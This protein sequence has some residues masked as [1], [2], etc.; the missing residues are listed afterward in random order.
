MI[1]ALCDCNNFFVSCERR[2]DPSLEGLPVIVLSHNDGCVI[3]RSNEAK[4]LNIGMAVPFFTVRGICKAHG[5]VALKGDHTLY[6]QTSRDVM[7]C[8]G[9]LFPEVEVS[10]IDEAYLLL[11]GIQTLDP[12]R[13]CL[14]AR[15]KL[16][17]STGIPASFGIAPTKTL[18]KIASRF[19]KK[20]PS[21]NGVFN[22]LDH[23][24]AD[25]LLASLSV[26]DVWGIGSRSLERLRQMG[27]RTAL[28]L[29]NA[30]DEKLLKRF[31]I[32]M[33]RTSHEL[34]GVCC[35]SF[36]P[37]PESH[38]SI[39]IAPSFR[40][41]VTD[42]ET[43]QSTAAEHAVEAAKTLR[44]EG[45]VCGVVQVSIQTNPFR[46]DLPQYEATA[47]QRIE[48]PTDYS[49]LLADAA[50]QATEK[51]Y[52]PGYAYRRVGVVLGDL[53]DSSSRQSLLF[54]TRDRSREKKLMEAMDSINR[55]LG[56]DTI[57]PWFTKE[58]PAE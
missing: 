7:E 47:D 24:A 31:P 36:E 43:L 26:G 28:D 35:H 8:L 5:V 25:D 50:R 55:A 34:R 42:L 58:T 2:R 15:G 46:K 33:L 4:A 53:S 51:I 38:K 18:A 20:D 29:K 12:A 40:K 22:F 9:G 37:D 32:G 44:A 27:I 3:A 41:P 11:T 10:S 19:S 48:E 49:P 30:D 17:L 57:K 6:R 39:Q 14:G 21:Y 56:D 23:P 1:I 16:L 54:S 45:L 52:K 13:T